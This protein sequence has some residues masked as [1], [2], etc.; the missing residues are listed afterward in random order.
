MNISKIKTESTTEVKGQIADVI[1]FQEK[2]GKLM[3]LTEVIDSLSPL[4][5]VVVLAGDDP[6]L[7]YREVKSLIEE[8]KDKKIILETSSFNRDLHHICDKVVFIFKTYDMVHENVIQ[9][10]NNHLDKYVPVAIGDHENFNA[11]NFAMLCKILDV[12]YVR[13]PEGGKSNLIE[14]SQI[15]ERYETKLIEMDKIPL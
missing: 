9:H 6:S 13:I 8:I 2:G 12:L 7:Q 15:A 14:M 3:R 4:S 1:Y 11:E 5:S 10:I